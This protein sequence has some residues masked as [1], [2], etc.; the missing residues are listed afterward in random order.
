MQISSVSYMLATVLSL[1]LIF[2]LLKAPCEKSTGRHLRRETLVL[3]T[4][5]LSGMTYLCKVG[6]GI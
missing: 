5:T 1:P 6:I 4:Q 2:Q 3:F